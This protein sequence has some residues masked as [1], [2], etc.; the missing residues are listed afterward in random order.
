MRNIEQTSAELFD[1]LRNRFSQ[2]ETRDENRK[3]T[4]NPK[5][6][7][8]FSFDYVSDGENFGPI[9]IS[10]LDR[11]LKIFYAKDLDAV[12][13]KLQKRKW[14]K[15]LKDLRFFAMPEVKDFDVRDISKS[16]LNLHDL[17]YLNKDSEVVT[18]NEVSVN[19][20]KLY[21]S[22]RTSYQKLEN[23][24]IIAR[25][26][27]PI[28]DETVPGAR[29]RNIESFYIEN[30]QG[31]R[32]KLPEGTTIN[33]ARAYARHVK[34]GGQLHDD[35]S[36]HVGRIIKEMNDLR[37]FVRNMRGRTF[38]DIQTQQM[39][40]SAI[41]HY[42]KLHRDLHLIRSQRGYEQYRS[43]WQPEILEENDFDINELR[44]RFVRKVFDDRI[45]D[46]LPVV[47]REYRRRK[48]ATE[49]EFE[50]WANELVRE[51]E[52]KNP[53]DQHNKKAAKDQQDLEEEDSTDINVKSPFANSLHNQERDSADT[54]VDGDE[55]QNLAG[56]LNEKGFE[57]RFSDGVYYFES[58]DEIERAKDWISLKFPKMKFPKMGVF[59]YGYGVYGS[60]TFDRESPGG[61][62]VMESIKIDPDKELPYYLYDEPETSPYVVDQ[63]PIYNIDWQS[64]EDEDEDFH[65]EENL[66]KWFKEKWVR[67]GPDGKIRGQCARDDDSEG[68]PKCLPQA[69]AHAL[70]KK[71]RARAARR[72]RRLDPNAD[73]SGPAINVK[74]KES[75]QGVAEGQEDNTLYDKFTS[76]YPKIKLAL[77]ILP[78]TAMATSA[79]DTLNSLSKN[80]Y[81][82]AVLN[83]LGLIPG[84]K[85]LAKLTGIGNIQKLDQIRQAAKTVDMTKDVT[86]YAKSELG[87]TTLSDTSSDDYGQI[88]SA[89]QG[90]PLGV[91]ESHYSVAEGRSKD[92][93]ERH[94]AAR[95]MEDILD[96]LRSSE[97]PNVNLE[98][99][100]KIKKLVAITGRGQTISGFGSAGELLDKL[101][102][103][104]R[105]SQIRSGQMPQFTGFATSARDMARQ[106]ANQT[107]G[108]YRYFNPQSWTHR[109]GQRYRDP[110]DYVVYPD[111]QSYDDAVEWIENKGK[112]V[113]YRDHFGD[114][115]DATQI[116]R[117]IIEPS[118]F[119]QGAF[120][121]TPETTHRISVRLAKTINQGGRE[122]VDI[123][124]QQA[125]A[126]HDI[127]ATRS[128]NAMQSVQSIMAVLR[129]MSDVKRVIANSKKIHPQDKAKLDAIIANAGKF[130]EPGG[131]QGVAEGS[132]NE[133]APGGGGGDD[134]NRSKSTL[135]Q[136]IAYIK[137]KY[138]YFKKYTL[139]GS[140]RYINPAAV[141]DWVKKGEI[142]SAPVD[143]MNHALEH[144]GMSENPAMS[145]MD[146]THIGREDWWHTYENNQIEI[147]ALHFV[148]QNQGWIIIAGNTEQNLADAVQV[149]RNSGIL[150]DLELARQTRRD[151]AA[152]RQSKL[153]TTPLALG[154]Y[155]GEEVYNGWDIW[156]VLEFTKTGKIKA[157]KVKSTNPE[158]M[159]DEGVIKLFNPL[160]R[161][162]NNKKA[163][164]V[165]QEYKKSQQGVSEAKLSAKGQQMRA[166]EFITEAIE[167]N[168]T[169]YRGVGRQELEQIL[170]TKH[171]LPSSDLM[172]F[173]NEIIE[174]SIGEESFQDMSPE[175]VEQWVRDTVPW[176]NGSLQ[177]VQGGVN[178]TTDLDNAE[179]YG[180]YILALQVRGDH[181]D[182]SDVHGFA[183]NYKDVSV[184]A[185]KKRGSNK[186]ITIK[187][188]QGVAEGSLNEFAPPSDSGGDD[189][190]SK[191]TLKMLAAQWWNGDE[192]PGVERTLKLAGWE[193]GQDEGSDEPA[194][195]VVLAG[196]IN[197][198]SYLSWPIK[199]LEG[200]AEATGDAKFDAMM[201]NIAQGVAARKNVD[202]IKTTPS[203][204]N[205]E[206]ML[207]KFGMEL[208]AQ[209]EK[210]CR[211]RCGSD[212][213]MQDKPDIEPKLSRLANNDDGGEKVANILIDLYKISP[214]DL[215]EF[216]QAF[217]QQGLWSWQNFATAWT[218]GEWNDYKR[219]WI[220]Y[221]GS[222]RKGV[223]ESKQKCPECGGPLMLFSQLNE[224][225]DACYYKVKSTAKV[226]PS[227]YAS[228]RLVQCR[229]K[230]AKNWGKKSESTQLSTTKLLNSFKS[231]L[232]KL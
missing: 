14:F 170:K 98:I 133:F 21:G 87:P 222:L 182:F 119:T 117:Y 39:V 33:G 141:A 16:G 78:P 97:S 128:A 148:G 86:D 40:E 1:K 28:V 190:F 121:D 26:S 89:M 216:A 12:M 160:G 173:D 212:R 163:I 202:T 143:P 232:D 177:S 195:F 151:K 197:G 109:S 54:I 157:E 196:D 188:N 209:L 179:G 176:Y 180:E 136:A 172:P 5:E 114:L 139:D 58:R 3:Q 6:A 131:Q 43:L 199:E 168:V 218:Q 11:S 201:A 112:K 51:F 194:V 132:L 213:T 228:G 108:E 220:D 153:S 186:W 88:A 187:P 90:T 7:R 184:V 25:H 115:T 210:L 231:S 68:K 35:F 38:E 203:Q 167:D 134:D 192:D 183:K 165:G 82:D 20:A 211:A 223:A 8:F 154:D 219:Q 9:T 103:M 99:I 79:T 24:R 101:T 214:D 85:P 10:L 92:F 207:A 41:D 19:E 118:S 161:L 100:K 105:Q 91:K 45:T 224:K 56:L 32:F 57:F 104:Y 140:Y 198:N 178:Y 48:M 221:V 15:F 30:S 93:A 193:I 159:R 53:T 62:G 230:G 96:N 123:T 67:F 46:A 147:A 111:Q 135:K 66:R 76:E 44:E 225:K 206:A 36:K 77:D 49:Q 145:G 75:Q 116:G 31:E 229:K 156:K 106:I 94:Y 64:D 63:N 189:G 23:V 181:V 22:K 171:A 150:P 227:A 130:Q 72:K 138:P 129:G 164:A 152:S 217:N 50:S 34:N 83:A 113:R 4:L 52:E 13:S 191:E 162:I 127:A 27:K 29:S 142:G 125:A 175:E 73:R 208:I 158:G 144:L 55:N 2:I 155:F 107:R 185:Y 37:M 126:L 215:K 174:Y 42:G 226:W 204:A 120:S 166:S 69:K 110:A 169:G 95:E 205:P 65:L 80:D 47:F 81:G 84:L 122:Q 59:D 61:K 70:G 124:D 102:D 74:T 17:K 71:G 200:L 18:K 146:A 149:F 60:T 137:N